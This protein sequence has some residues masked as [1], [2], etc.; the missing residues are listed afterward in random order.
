MGHHRLVNRDDAAMELGNAA[1]LWSAG[2]LSAADVVR[3]ACDGL[4]A[5]LDGSALRMLAAVPYQNADDEAPEVLEAALDELGLEHHA[6]GS[7]SGLV[8]AVK[9]LSARALAE[10]VTP[11][12]LAS[13]AHRRIGHDRIRLAERLVE[14]D[15][16][17]DCLEY[18]DQTVGE[19]DEDVLAEARRI[20]DDAEPPTA[21]HSV[22]RT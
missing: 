20:V 16:V 21:P 22:D 8:A 3:A 15:D 7:Q 10:R 4:V 9:A 1:A 14:L 18:T 13:W 5:G 17:Y 19:T 11:R 12:E 2:Y 6:R